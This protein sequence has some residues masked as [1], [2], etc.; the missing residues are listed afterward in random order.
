MSSWYRL[1]KV[2]PSRLSHVLDSQLTDGGEVV[3]TIHLPIT[4]KTISW[5]SF[6][7]EVEFT[8]WPYPCEK[9]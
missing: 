4:P 3:F 5:Y 6:L 2:K 8:P 7:L 9:E 1:K